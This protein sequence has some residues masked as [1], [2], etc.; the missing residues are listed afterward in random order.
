MLMCIINLPAVE[1]PRKLSPLLQLR[2][3]KCVVSS[4]AVHIAEGAAAYIK[5]TIECCNALTLHFRIK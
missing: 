4:V 5:L 2:C 1:K 3:L